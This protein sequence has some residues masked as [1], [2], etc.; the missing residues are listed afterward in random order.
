[1]KKVSVTILAA[2]SVS[3]IAATFA[4]APKIETKDGVRV[5]HNEKG[6]KLGNNPKARIELIRTIGGLDAH[7]ILAF[8]QKRL[9]DVL[10][11]SLEYCLRLDRIA[12]FF[13]SQE[14]VRE[15]I[16]NPYRIMMRPGGWKLEEHT[17]SYDYQLIRKTGLE[18]ER[19]ILIREN[20]KTCRVEDAPLKTL[21]FNYKYLAFGPIGLLGETAQRIHSYLVEDE[22]KIWRKPAL[23]IRIVPREPDTARWLYGRAWVSPT[24]GSVFKIEWQEES[25]GNYEETLKYAQALKAKPALRFATEYQYEKN[26]IRFP[27]RFTVEEDYSQ[28]TPGRT[29]KIR[30]SELQ[31]TLRDYKFFTVETDVTVRR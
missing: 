13:I 3:I 19:R 9:D 24:D 11:K 1:M 18:E 2:L 14:D 17:Y 28:A 6:G 27:S 4:S 15:R 21:R 23:V 20:G 12:L 29:R 22:V 31:V 26:G 5:I 30:K 7:E 8:N 25:L 10:Q 16:F